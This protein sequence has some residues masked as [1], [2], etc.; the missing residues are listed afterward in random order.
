MWLRVIRDEHLRVHRL[1]PR[2][3]LAPL[4]KPLRV[5]PR[6]FLRPR[7]APLHKPLRVHPRLLLQ[8]LR[9]EYNKTCKKH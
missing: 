3:R 1:L 9:A 7:L 5:H 8:L 2:P 6:L 4:H